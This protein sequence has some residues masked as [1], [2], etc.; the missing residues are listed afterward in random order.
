MATQKF[1]R[2]ES[3]MTIKV[4]AQYT[5][6]VAPSGYH[7]KRAWVKAYESIPNG[8]DESGKTRFLH[9]YYD[10]TCWGDV[11]ERV[12]DA[13]WAEGTVI[14]VAGNDEGKESKYTNP[15][16]GE[17]YT[18]KQLNECRLRYYGMASWYKPEAAA[19]PAA[20]SKA[21]PAPKAKAKPALAAKADTPK[22]RA[23]A[24]RVEVDAADLP[25]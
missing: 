3:Q 10:L 1:T 17:I 23:S 14:I 16:T 19:A 22:P 15:K 2:I 6:G 24:K 21:D 11:A 7:W 4:P 20:Q 25:F 9:K 18:S 8:V 13:G 12:R 5:E